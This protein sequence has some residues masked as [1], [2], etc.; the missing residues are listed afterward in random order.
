MGGYSGA[1]PFSEET[2]K[3][4]DAEVLKIIGESH[5]EAKRLLIKYREQLDALAKALIDRETLDEQEI[6][7]VTALPRASTLENEKLPVAIAASKIAEP[8]L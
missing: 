7:R 2:A 4:I 8:S 1:K 5:Q 6:L 3:A